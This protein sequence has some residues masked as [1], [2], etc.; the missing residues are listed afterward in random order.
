MHVLEALV[1]LNP[2]ERE[3][4]VTSTTLKHGKLDLTQLLL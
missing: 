2:I 1:L 4:L 3:Q